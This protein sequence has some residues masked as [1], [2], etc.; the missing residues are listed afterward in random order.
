M[1]L[2][3]TIDHLWKDHLLA[4]DHLREGI[5]LQ[6]YGQK[7]PLIEYKKEGYRFFQ[8]MMG[9][10]TGD[11]VRKLYS[12]QL[13]AQENLDE[14]EEEAFG[15]P[16]A[17]A[18]ESHA[19]G[20][21]L[22]LRPGFP[23]QPMPQQHQ[24]PN[25]AGAGP[26][27]AGMQYAI[28]PDG[29]LVPQAAPA[30]GGSGGG[31]PGTGGGGASSPAQRQAMDFSNLMRGPSRMTMGRGPVGGGSPGPQAAAASVGQ[32]GSGTDV[33]KVG[34]NDVCPCGSGKKYKKCHGA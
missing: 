17:H 12:V 15:D 4:M 23:G 8:M 18:V 25:N 21:G 7:D 5:G 6:G 27:R 34:R 3:T 16:L 22:G 28:G 33:E 30:Q 1:I 31:M 29:S 26:S 20:Q 2:L 11:V 32:G 24:Q 10:I 9:Q 19:D 14:L 13:A